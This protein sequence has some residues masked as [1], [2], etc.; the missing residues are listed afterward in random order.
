[1]KATLLCLFFA[2]CLTTAAAQNGIKVGYN[3]ATIGGDATGISETAGFHAGFF[4]ITRKQR[5][6]TM[7]EVLYSSQGAEV[8]G[9]GPKLTYHYVLVPV[10]INFYLSEG[11]FA[12]LGAQPGVLVGADVDGTDV[13]D[14]LSRLDFAAALGLGGE[15]EQFMINAR[16]NYGISNTSKQQSGHYPN[17]V[18]Q[19]SMGIKLGK[20]K[21][22]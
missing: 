2:G 11:F 16:Y 13:L 19:F 7:F 17:M 14:Q 18:F 3:H 21:V 8:T 15:F 12:Q 22:E 4:F 5:T 1:M 6:S 10:M 20:K 9:G